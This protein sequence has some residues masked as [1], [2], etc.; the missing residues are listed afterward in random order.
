MPMRPQHWVFEPPVRTIPREWL[1]RGDCDA[2]DRFVAASR[3]PESPD[4]LFIPFV[5][6]VELGRCSRRETPS[7]LRRPP[8][9]GAVCQ[10]NTVLH[11][12]ADA[13]EGRDVPN[14]HVT[15]QLGA[16]VGASGAIPPP[17]ILDWFWRDKQHSPS[18]KQ[19]PHGG[20]AYDARLSG[21]PGRVALDDLRHLF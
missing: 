20:P 5:R 14:P 10:G 13:V 3:H 19:N 18:T 8:Q 15:R 2:C 7:S 4:G 9:S 17:L 11:D 16:G 12:W 6:G 1:V 21:Q